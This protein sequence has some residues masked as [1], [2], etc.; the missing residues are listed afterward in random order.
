MPNAINL[1]SRE[2]RWIE[3]VS[4]PAMAETP[5]PE[6]DWS[7]V[8]HVYNKRAGMKENV[9]QEIAQL[10][11]VLSKAPQNLELGVQLGIFRQE[12]VDR[13]KAKFGDDLNDIKAGME[14]LFLAT[15][16]Q[17][18]SVK[19]LL[20]F[21]D[22]GARV[23]TEAGI[24]AYAD[25]STIREIIVMEITNNSGSVVK[26]PFYKSSG[27]NSNMPSRWLP[28]D[29]IGLMGFSAWVNKE[30]YDSNIEIDANS[31]TEMEQR[32]GKI[33]DPRYFGKLKKTGLAR[34]GHPLLDKISDAITDSDKKLFPAPAVCT[35]TQVNQFLRKNGCDIDSQK[36]SRKNQIAG[37]VNSKETMSKDMID[38]IAKEFGVADPEFQP[39]Q[40]PIKI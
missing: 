32:Y 31:N 17:K 4:Q 1:K 18:K 19:E 27:G 35:M 15:N 11:T 22:L 5:K 21:R 26:Q 39:T 8:N 40:F 2:S 10:L 38:K 25:G 33:T 30:L 29:G 24:V 34:F 6:K 14:K 36:H 9:S 13:F 3:T 16:E 37:F 28:F 7:E 20:T 12:T 23:C